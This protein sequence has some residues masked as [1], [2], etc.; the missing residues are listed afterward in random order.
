MSERLFQQEPPARQMT[1]SL[2]VENPQ[3]V[4]SS[5]PQNKVFPNSL[6]FL[7]G[8]NMRNESGPMSN[9]VGLVECFTIMQ[10]ADWSMAHR[11]ADTSKLI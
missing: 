8:T 7:C 1:T 9:R 4:C 11:S 3:R 10:P 2:A 5:E 6:P